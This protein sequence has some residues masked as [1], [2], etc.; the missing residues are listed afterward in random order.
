[1]PLTML[2]AGEP[3]GSRQSW[4]GGA[5]LPRSGERG[6]LQEQTWRRNK[7]W[8]SE[9]PGF[10]LVFYADPSGF[11]EIDRCRVLLFSLRFAWPFVFRKR[12]LAT[13]RLL[14][15]TLE[16]SRF[17]TALIGRLLIYRLKVRRG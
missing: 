2:L 14:Q 16:W 9:V 17:T 6:Y 5:N 15:D 8:R 7:N 12:L 1:M 10:T 3:N 11:L 4:L 13:N